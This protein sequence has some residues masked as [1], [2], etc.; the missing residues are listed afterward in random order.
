MPFNFSKI[1]PSFPLNVPLYLLLI[2][3]FAV[4]KV[5]V[6]HIPAMLTKDAQKAPKPT[7]KSK[8]TCARC[9]NHGKVSDFK[10]F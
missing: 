6:S 9:K 2:S 3:R 4:D 8:P 1:F 5:P 7:V 10:K